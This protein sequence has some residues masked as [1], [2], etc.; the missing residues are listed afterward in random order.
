MRGYEETTDLY[1]FK[2]FDCYCHLKEFS[3]KG[4]KASEDD[5]GEGVDLDPANAPSCG[6]GGRAFNKFNSNPM[7]LDKYGIT[8]KEYDEIANVLSNQLSFGRCRY[9]D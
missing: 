8:E 3:I 6:C 7:V 1:H 2:V 5:F 9:C 4:K